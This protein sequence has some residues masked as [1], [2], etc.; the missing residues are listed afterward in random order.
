[1]LADAT[2]WDEDAY[3]ES[4]YKER[5]LQT[6]TVF[7]TAWAPSLSGCPETIVVASSDGSIASYSIASCIS[8]LVI[9]LDL[10]ILVFILLFDLL[11]KLVLEWRGVVKLKDVLRWLLW[12]D[13]LVGTFHFCWRRS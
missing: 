6:Q 12:L 10:L 7:R 1:M 4:V 2:N 13:F 3:R 5:E 11:M 8:K 9:F